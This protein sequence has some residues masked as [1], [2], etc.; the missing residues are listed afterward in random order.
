MLVY[1]LRLNDAWKQWMENLQEDA[2][3]DFHAA[4]EARKNGER[5][6]GRLDLQHA[7]QERTRY[8]VPRSEED[9][10]KATQKLNAKIGERDTSLETPP[11]ARG[12]LN[13]SKNGRDGVA[14]EEVIARLRMLGKD[15]EVEAILKLRR[16]VSKLRNLLLDT[17]NGTTSES[18]EMPRD[19][20]AMVAK[21]EATAA[22]QVVT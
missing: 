2:R 10:A 4:R 5:H 12:M 7:M 8:E 6:G 22:A 20:N 1:F 16:S 11:R 3:Q 13:V 9:N 15:A 18:T 14:K 17:V 19:M 21:A